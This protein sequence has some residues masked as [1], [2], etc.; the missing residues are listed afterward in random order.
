MSVH[1]SLFGIEKEVK[2]R[3]LFLPLFAVMAIL[4]Q[5]QAVATDEKEEYL[6]TIE[7]HPTLRT[8]FNNVFDE[9]Y[10]KIEAQTGCRSSKFSLIHWLNKYEDKRF[11]FSSWSQFRKDD[12]VWDKPDR[13]MPAEPNQVSTVSDALYNL[14]LERSGVKIKEIKDYYHKE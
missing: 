9:T 4:A 12:F 1:F 6:S 13:E 10:K 8:Q 2:M 11:N 3:K 14:F 5:P 7:T